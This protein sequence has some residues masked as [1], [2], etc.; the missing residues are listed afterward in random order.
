MVY[1]V[2]GV[3]GPRAAV[4]LP[5]GIVGSRLWSSRRDGS[6]VRSLLRFYGTC[7]AELDTLPKLN[8]NVERRSAKEAPKIIAE[9]VW[10]FGTSL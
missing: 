2:L 9:C 5:L 3:V 8:T 10:C 7:H 1:S 6:I 4:V